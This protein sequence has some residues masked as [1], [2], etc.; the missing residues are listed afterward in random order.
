MNKWNLLTNTAFSFGSE[1]IM[2]M[3]QPKVSL[4]HSTVSGCLLSAAAW[5]LFAASPA[6]AA[7]VS[8]YSS[9][10]TF[11]GALQSSYIENYNSLPA[12]GQHSGPLNFSGNGYSY[13]VDVPGDSLYVIDYPSDAGNYALSTLTSDY[14][15]VFTFGSGIQGV[16]G[17]FFLTD[18]P[19][20]SAIGSITLTLNDGTT[21]T[22]TNP[23]VSGF[24]GF[25]SS[26]ADITS[27]TISTGTAG[28][29]ATADNLYVGEAAG[30]PSGN[31]HPGPGNAPEPA[32]TV[33]MFSGL[34]A[35]AFQAY[36]K[37]T[38]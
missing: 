19:G 20:N 28:V 33:L 13:A 3:N 32:S 38:A 14:S 27:L 31:G 10:A 36:R 4:K 16:G 5:V 22:L 11:L 9:T 15:L 17:S 35:G 6:S 25:I 18:D 29:F 34:A 24:N 30:G 26:G 12:T 7:S 23:G 8:L 1:R 2:K 37:R 21:E